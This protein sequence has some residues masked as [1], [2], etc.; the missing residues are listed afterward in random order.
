MVFLRGL[1]KTWSES[2]LPSCKTYTFHKHSSMLGECSQKGRANVMWSLEML[3]IN[4]RSRLTPQGYPASPGQG[5]AFKPKQLRR[6]WI[7]RDQGEPDRCCTELGREHRAGVGLERKTKWAKLTIHKEKVQ[8]ARDQEPGSPISKRRWK[9]RVLHRAPQK[10]GPSSSAGN[11]AC[12]GWAL[13]SLRA[14]RCFLRDQ[15]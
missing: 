5:H 12:L 6:R 14:E 8:L 9:H 13:P 15:S 7:C 3:F 2:P 4:P 1:Q 11:W 10:P